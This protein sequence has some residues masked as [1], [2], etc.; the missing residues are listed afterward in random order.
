MPAKKTAHTK[1]SKPTKKKIEEPKEAAVTAAPL[2]APAVVVPPKPSAPP[3]APKLPP[4]PKPPAPPAPKNAAPSA[5]P[6]LP[7]K[8]MVAPVKPLVMQ[9]PEAVSAA[10]PMANT[11]AAMSDT[12]AAMH[13]KVVRW[14]IAVA[15]IAGTVLV[16]AGVGYWMMFV[17]GRAAPPSGTASQ[18]EAQLPVDNTPS[19]SENFVVQPIT[20]DIVIAAPTPSPSGEKVDLTTGTAPAPIAFKSFEYDAAKGKIINISGTCTDTYYA[21]LVFAAKDD[22]RKD[23]A[24]AK[25]NK[26]FPCPEAKT[27]K[28][29]LDLKDFNLATGEYYLFLADQGDGAWYNP[30]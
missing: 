6:V 5:S 20:E 14:E 11:I 30:R 1:G 9:K 24:V 4:P 27:F 2:E 29:V 16:V 22:Y 25:T 10:I 21:L 23:P 19:R 8:P 3:V 15:A 28:Q 17:R 26:A 18:A 13:K 7:P 12:T